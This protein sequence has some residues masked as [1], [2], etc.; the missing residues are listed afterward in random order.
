MS[1]L[2]AARTQM[3]LSLGFHIIFA[4]VGMAMP[5][6]MVIAE[7]L[8]L[9]TQN[10][11]YLALAKRWS[12]GV[13]IMFAVGAVSGTV[14]SFELGLLWPNFMEFAGPII[15]MPFSLEGFAFFL[16]AIFLGIYLYG[17][18][19][20]PKALH[21]LSGV[22]VLVAGT[23][24]GVFVVA[25]NGWM[26]SPRGFVLNAAGEV[27]SVDPWAA[28][29]NDAFPTQALHMVLA[30]FCA[31]GVAVAGIH[32]VAL[33]RR[34]Q[35]PFHRAAFGI[36]MSVGAV[37]ALLQ[38][39]SGDLSAKSVA[40]RQPAKLAA[41]EGHWETERGASLLIGGWPDEEAEETPYGIHLPNMLSFLAFGDFDAEVT[42]LKDIPK[43]ER[44]P[45]L[46][47][48]LAFQVMVGCGMA[49]MLVG[50]VFL[51]LWM[52]R[53]AMPVDRWLLWASAVVAPM[54]VIAVEA[55]WT[56]T[57]V[58]RQPWVIHGVMRTADAVT[59]MQG[60]GYSLALYTA[61][62]IG[63]GVVVVV[64]LKRQVFQTFEALP[65]EGEAAVDLASTTTP[66][67]TGA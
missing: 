11:L 9:R 55:G 39:L 45:V 10:P 22:G 15:G 38:P 33:L 64:L 56:V 53:R 67:Q 63:L 29:W 40:K 18:A 31:V 19:K 21:W 1:E 60:L 23:L 34:P 8:W 47:P 4:I 30:A 27:V 66:K 52:K 3:A 28:L 20:V 25:A 58:G 43:D 62:Y 59:P 61:V 48:H 13:A 37:F 7:G 6:L 32:A 17:W 42:G 35:S 16:E 65:E 24:S 14:L 26:N 36:A 51:G 5:M 54:G 57:E 49:M 12:K 41:M 44:P 2:F 50:G 46:V